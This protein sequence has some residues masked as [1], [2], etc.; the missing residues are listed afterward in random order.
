MYN[1]KPTCRIHL[2]EIK[3][4]GLGGAG[5]LPAPSLLR[6]GAGTK[7]GRVTDLDGFGIAMLFFSDPDGVHLELTDLSNSVVQP[8]RLNIH[9]CPRSGIERLLGLPSLPTGVTV[10]GD[11]TGLYAGRRAV[12]DRGPGPPR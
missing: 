2:Y 9:S 6:L 7:H 4:P 8:D 12:D 3:S 1:G 11:V 10:H 5:R